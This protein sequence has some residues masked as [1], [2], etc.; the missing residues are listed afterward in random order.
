MEFKNLEKTKLNGKIKK[1]NEKLY[2]KYD[3]PAR[4][5]IKKKLGDLV[6]DNE[7]I[8]AED[9][10]ITDPKCKYKFLELQVCA[11]WINDYPYDKPFVYERKGHFSKDTLFMIFDKNF[12]KFLMFDKKSLEEKP[13]RIKKYSRY[14]IY[15]VPRSRTVQLYTENFNIDDIYIFQL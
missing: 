10:V 7:D 1:F 14:F 8:Y 3:I 5:L 6:K 12:T 2:N 4:D 13:V 15:Q 9:M 11:T